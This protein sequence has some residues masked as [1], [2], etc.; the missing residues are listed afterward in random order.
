V[1]AAAAAEKLNN[2]AD[3]NPGHSKEGGQA[4]HAPGDPYVPPPHPRQLSPSPDETKG[5]L[6]TSGAQSAR[7]YTAPGEAGCLFRGHTNV[8]LDTHACGEYAPVA[9][10]PVPAGQSTHMEREV[11]PVAVP[12]L[13]AGQGA[14][15]TEPSESP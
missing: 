6:H 9:S 5:A 2:G 10:V 15:D 11:A 1:G 13:P 12:N 4:A 3:A 8:A 7:E 14:Q